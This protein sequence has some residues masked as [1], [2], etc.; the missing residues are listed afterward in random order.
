MARGDV[1]GDGYVN[2]S[3]VTFIINCILGKNNS[4]FSLALVDVNADG[5]V[6]MSDVTMVIS[7]IL[8]KYQEDDYDVM[9]DTDEAVGVTG[10]DIESNSGAFD[11]GVE[12]DTGLSVP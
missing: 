11:S 1:N 9:I 8:G 7:I 4:D 2:M 10:G 6:N 12:T 3:D 5:Y